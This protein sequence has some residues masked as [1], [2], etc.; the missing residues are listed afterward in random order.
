MF[1]LFLSILKL[2]LLG[3][4]VGVLPLLVSFMYDR[5]VTFY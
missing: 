3:R 4:R 5:G 1:D 2:C